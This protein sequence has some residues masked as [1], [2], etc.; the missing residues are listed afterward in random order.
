MNIE[1][2]LTQYTK[3]LIP[4]EF[5]YKQP[6]LAYSSSVFHLSKIIVQRQL[7]S[8]F[9]NSTNTVFV[10]EW[11]AALKFLANVLCI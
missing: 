10:N 5:L 1:N 4:P 6:V 11:T 8:Q 7:F 9:T 2:K 3:K